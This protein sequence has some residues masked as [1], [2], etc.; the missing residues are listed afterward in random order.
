MVLIFLPQPRATVLKDV[1]ELSIFFF[2]DPSY[3][4]LEAKTLYATINRNFYGQSTP[5]SLVPPL[6]VLQGRLCRQW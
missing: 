2:L 6:T 5:H 3:D 1:P 4:T